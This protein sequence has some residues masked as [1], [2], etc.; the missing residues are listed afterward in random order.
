MDEPDFFSRIPD[1]VDLGLAEPLDERKDRKDRRI[2]ICGHSSHVHGHTA[3]GDEICRSQAAGG[4][5]QCKCSRHR[6]VMTVSNK[7]FFRSVTVGPGAQHALSRGVEKLKASLEAKKAEDPDA[8]VTLPGYEW[9]EDPAC[10]MCGGTDQVFPVAF[11]DDRNVAT[12]PPMAKHHYFIC[13]KCYSGV[14]K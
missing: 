7:R 12:C 1:L 14:V 2:C 9:L 13:L 11:D 6:P 3:R 8:E 4:Q 10:E 5:S